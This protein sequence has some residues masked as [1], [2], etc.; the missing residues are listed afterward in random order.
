MDFIQL[1]LAIPCLLDMSPMQDLYGHFTWRVFC[2]YKVRFS[3][4]KPEMAGLFQFVCPALSSLSLCKSVS[5][6]KQMALNISCLITSFKNKHVSSHPY[7][8]I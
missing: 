7:S 8:V 1:S 3:R 5:S 2:M 4:S 6:W